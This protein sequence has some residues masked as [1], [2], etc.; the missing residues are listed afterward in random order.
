[1]L[2][3]GVCTALQIANHPG[4]L[5][6]GAAL[7]LAAVMQGERDPYRRI[8]ATMAVALL[9]GHEEQ[10]PLLRVDEAMARELLMV[11]ACARARVLCH[12]YFWTTWKVGLARVYGAPCG[13]RL[14]C[15]AS[16]Y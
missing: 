2:T 10:H 6:A 3:C 13:P 12:G 16:P 15:G 5:A 11:L 1:M 14:G 9:V 7:E 8:N 4:L